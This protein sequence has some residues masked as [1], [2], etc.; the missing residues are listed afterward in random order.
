MITGKAFFTMKLQGPDVRPGRVRLDDFL[1]L[2]QEVLRA[3][4]RVGLVLQGS[5]DS[6]R[7]GRRPQDLRA[8]ISLDIVEVTHGSPAAVVRFERSQQQMAIPGADVGA[9]AFEKFLEGL[10][11]ITSSAEG[12]PNGFDAGVLLAV[13]DAGRVFDRG[14]E[15]IEFTLG[16][17]TE[18]LRARYDRVGY[19]TIQTRIVGPRHNQRTIEGRLMMADFKESGARF[20]VHPSSGDAVVCLFDESLRD[21]VFRSI[22]RFVRVTG[23]AAVDAASNRI[24]SIRISDIERVETREDEVREVLP[25]G[26]PLPG[27]FWNALSFDELAT[28]QG[29]GPLVNLDGLAGAW[30]GDV[31]DGFEESIR[32]L[33][34]A[35][36]RAN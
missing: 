24:V 3:V 36:P 31:N 10:N 8:A 25:T 26:A 22:L 16:H 19:D 20:R 27:D 4:E 9:A 14:I 5:A 35:S 17:R 30:P 11:V 2:G 1:R 32:N 29:V 21:E 34:Q 18:P 7:A 28:V 33:R 13:R 15:S 23:E 12:L 6:Q